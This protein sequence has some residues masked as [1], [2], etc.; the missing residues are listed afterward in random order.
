VKTVYGKVVC[1]SA[2]IWEKQTF[3]SRIRCWAVLK[4]ARSFAV[5]GW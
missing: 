3:P 2:M 5:P 4:V 1:F